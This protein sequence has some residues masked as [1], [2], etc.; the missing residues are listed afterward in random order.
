LTF[1]FNTLV[2][3]ILTA[4][5]ASNPDMAIRG[6]LKDAVSN[7]ADIISATPN[8]GSD[9]D[10]LYE[11][12]RVSIWWC[13]FETNVLIPAHEHRMDV[14]IAGYSGAEKQILFTRDEAGLH[15]KETVTVHPGEIISLDKSCIHSVIAEGNIPACSIHVYRGPLSKTSRGLFDWNTGKEYPFSQ[16]KFDA[17]TRPASELPD[18]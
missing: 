1:S 7:S 5:D 6:V 2:A 15:F 13:R 16:E 8:D 3:N 17:L 10:M 14:Y 9:G 4:V 18:Y 11:D 12:E